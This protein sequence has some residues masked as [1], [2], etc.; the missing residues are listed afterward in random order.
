MMSGWLKTFKLTNKLYNTDERYTNI[1]LVH[2]VICLVHIWS[3]A[4]NAEL[5][6]ILIKPKQDFT[7]HSLSKGTNPI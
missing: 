1:G 4:N 3:Y 2:F 6:E 7:R 5:K